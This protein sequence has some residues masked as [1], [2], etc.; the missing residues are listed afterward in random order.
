[1]PNKHVITSRDKWFL[2]KHMKDPV[3]QEQ[4]KIGDTIVICAKCKTAHYESSW[5][6]NSNKCCSAGC[7][8]SSQLN[9][10]TFSSDIFRP[11]I[12]HNSQFNVV[13]KKAPFTERVTQFN[14][15]PIANTF[16]IMI[17]MLLVLLLIYATQYHALP[18]RKMTKQLA[19]T[20]ERLTDFAEESLIKFGQLIEKP[21]SMNKNS[22]KKLNS[23]STSFDNV[24]TKT[25]AIDVTDK[26]NN[27]HSNVSSA[28]NHARKKLSK[29]F[30]SVTKF[31]GKIFE[32]S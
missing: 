23:I 13:I 30:N 20:Q 7:D 8:H 12:S 24:K 27:V 3:A 31:F 16:T 19:M 14:G 10:N 26:L 11:K 4:F 9:F 22:G 25:A 32:E 29:W 15:Y 28:S 2:D 1:M 17:P 6:M 5:S 21:K 18:T